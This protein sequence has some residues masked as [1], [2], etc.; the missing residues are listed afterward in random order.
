MTKLETD[1]NEQA[2]D[3]MDTYMRTVVIT[4]VVMILAITLAA[5]LWHEPPNG[6]RPTPGSV[7]SIEETDAA[8]AITAHPV[9]WL[10]WPG[11]KCL[12]VSGAGSCD[13][14][15]AMSRIG[16]AAPHFDGPPWFEDGKPLG[17][18]DIEFEPEYLH[19]VRPDGNATR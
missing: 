11:G 17:S 9:T 8:G 2:A 7:D 4:G 16:W 10:L 5:I 3:P 14:R 18:F 12:Y 19:R 13:N 6:T 1:R 15:P